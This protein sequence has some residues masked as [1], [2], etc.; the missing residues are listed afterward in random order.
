MEMNW[1]E[2]L[3]FNKVKLM[4]E[5]NNNTI[6]LRN[7]EKLMREEERKRQ[8]EQKEIM[9]NKKISDKIKKQ[10]EQELKRQER[11][12]KAIQKQLLKTLQLQPKYKKQKL[13]FDYKDTQKM[14]QYKYEKAK[15][16]PP[17]YCDCCSKTI[18]YIGWCQHTR[19]KEHINNNLNFR[20]RV[21]T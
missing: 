2:N 19:T 5:I 20:Q 14:S 4:H 13:D 6:V 18:S 3:V 17:R 21:T 9:K 8:Q 15:S 10:E 12:L 1:L 7:T 11:K 16:Y